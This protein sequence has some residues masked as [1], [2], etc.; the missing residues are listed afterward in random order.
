MSDNQI[1]MEQSVLK[2]FI[3]ELLIKASVNERDAKFQAECLVQTNLW[4]VDSHGVIRVPAYFGRML[5][6]GININPNIQKT[7]GF[8]ALEVLD[9]DGGS[10]FVVGKAAMDRAIELARVHGIGMVGVTNSNH[11]GAAALYS[12]MAAQSGMIGIAMTNVKPLIVA[13]GASRPVVGNN[14]FSVAIPTYGEFPF[15]LDV[16]LSKVAGG[17]LTLAI[18][19][20][21][22]I[23]MDWATDADGK[24]TDDPEK[25]FH[26]FLL[27]MGEHKGLGIAYVVDILTGVL[28][29]GVYG[30]ALKSMYANPEDPSLTCHTM[31]AINWEALMSRDEMKARMGEY[32]GKLKETPMWKEGAEMLIPGELEHRRSVERNENG[33]PIPKTTLEELQQLKDQMRVQAPLTVMS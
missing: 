6:G 15:I 10:G 2:E 33:I 4:G 32:C 1:K 7:S 25:A 18:K 22:K 27:P 23:P 13:S 28:N 3:T 24:P 16:A 19:K 11:F 26:G 17:K 31:L 5:N 30:H 9:G 8:G 21:D 14:P 12:N 29:G 20:G